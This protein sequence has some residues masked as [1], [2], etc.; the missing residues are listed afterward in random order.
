MIR[1]LCGKY[2]MEEP[3]TKAVCHTQVLYGGKQL[4]HAGSQLEA[5]PTE[6]DHLLGGTYVVCSEQSEQQCEDSG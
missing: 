3:Y 6:E 1:V 4:L 2:S 5:T